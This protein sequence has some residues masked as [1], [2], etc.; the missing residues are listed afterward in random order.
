MNTPDPELRRLTDAWHDGTITPEQ[1]LRLEQRLLNDAAARDYFFS[2]TE[3]EAAM[4]GAMA[5]LP[6]DLPVARHPVWHRW[7]RMAAVFVMG[8]FVGALML[9]SLPSKPLPPAASKPPAAMVT[10][11]LGVSWDGDPGE[12]SLGL[13]AGVT[14]SKIVTGLLELTFASGTRAVI[15]GP[16][17]F[18][19]L[20]DNSMSLSRGKL[21][22]DVPKGAEGFTVT[23]P[24]GR[25]VDLG[26]E[27]GVEVEESGHTANFGVFRGEIEYH[28][29][30]D[31]APP[32]RLLENHAV[33]ATRGAVVS[34]PFEQEKFTRK[35]PS[36]EFAWSCQGP[37]PGSMVWDFDIS[38]LV[39][40][41]GRYRAICKWMMG[42]HGIVING[43]EILRDG[44]LVAADPHTG[45]AGDIQ[46]TR[47][48]SFDLVIPAGAY[49]RARWTLRLRA[50]VSLQ[51]GT[52]V[53]S[54]GVILLEGGL[55]LEAKREDFIGTWE[56]LSFLADGTATLTV[57][58][59]T[60][61]SFADSRWHIESGCLVLD[62]ETGAGR[63][64]LER[65]LLRDSRTLVFTNQPYRNA[66]R[67]EP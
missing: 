10:G 22:A 67:V 66:I 5:R 47:D 13:T 28:R 56:Y 8:G 64:W 39:W 27:F 44:K 37:D 57:D 23:Y 11:M 35:L 59:K 24:D 33:R 38:H 25:I 43:A 51:S 36:R 45:M 52:T 54:V 61:P 32:V 21:V 34:V 20:G 40:N 30:D 2:I 16:A 41:A 4:A 3:I 58:G 14:E 18:R 12:R 65:H 63:R 31:A 42:D 26:T 19:V 6:Q 48:N 55:A 1:A 17:A 29:R 46:W 9:K 50:S 49:Q 15:E 62:V 7:W 60:Y 53:D